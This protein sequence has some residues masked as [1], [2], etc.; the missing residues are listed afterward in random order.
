MHCLTELD[1]FPDR[2]VAVEGV[3][4][5]TANVD[6]PRTLRSGKAPEKHLR[7]GNDIQMRREPYNSWSVVNQR[8]VAKREV[9]LSIEE[10]PSTSSQLKI[11]AR[12]SS[13]RIC[14]AWLATA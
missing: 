4:Y 7:V 11:I 8:R 2:H 6:M 5:P 10:Q 1:E 12:F 3:K 14:R 9:Q 13:A